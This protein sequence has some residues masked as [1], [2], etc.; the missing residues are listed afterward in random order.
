MGQYMVKWNDW[1]IHILN[2]NVQQNAMTDIFD[3][4]C[5]APKK[6]AYFVVRKK[7]IFTMTRIY[8]Q[9]KISYVI[10]LLGF[11]SIHLSNKKE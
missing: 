7:P 11:C 1:Y 3:A 9:Q 10:V 2:K 8:V 5:T 6:R 4:N